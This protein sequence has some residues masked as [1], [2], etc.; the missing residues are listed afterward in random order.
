MK[1]KKIPEW[2][3][4]GAY[5]RFLGWCGQITE[6]A[7]SDTENYVRIVGAKSIYSGQMRGDFVPV[8]EAA[9]QPAS[10]SELLENYLAYVRQEQLRLEKIL[11]MCEE[12]E[13]G[14]FEQ[15]SE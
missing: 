13:R 5:V 11:K 7:Q 14:E 9:M 2:V 6:I 3:R 8:D 12:V 1:N 10:S 4:V 15:E